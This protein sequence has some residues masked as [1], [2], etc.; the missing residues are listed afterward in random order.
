MKIG[1]R[2]AVLAAVCL[3]FPAVAQ[4]GAWP[5]AKSDTQLIITYEPGNADKGFDT[6]GG[7]TITL[8]KW[9]Q[10]NIS[11]FVDHGISEHLTLTAKINYRDYTTGTDSFSGLSSVEAGGRWTLKR[12]DD[13]VFAL[14]AAVEGFGKGRRNDYD[15]TDKGGTDYDLRAYAGKSFHLL[16]KPAFIDLQAARHLR[17]YEAN[18]WRVD[19]TLGIKPSPKWMV[20][21]QVFAGRTDKASW[22]YAVWANTELSV[23][24]SFGPRQ[25]TSV[26][27]GLRQTTS[28]RN[29]PAVHAVVVSLWKTC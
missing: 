2:L 1:L 21:A 26:Q 4:A 20:M 22:G 10:N 3:L 11:V 19:A 27:L 23:V 17:Q 29:V 14:G 12:T 18:E 28:G 24:R 25:Q 7:K 13:S 15:M 9:Q 16:G 6:S 5:Q 8:D